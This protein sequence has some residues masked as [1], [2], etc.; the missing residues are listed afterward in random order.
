MKFGLDPEAASL[1][2]ATRIERS[3][4]DP[5]TP[6]VVVTPP[7]D[8]VKSASAADMLAFGVLL[9]RTVQPLVEFE[10]VTFW[11]AEA[12][13]E[14]TMSPLA[15]VGVCDVFVMLVPFTSVEVVLSSDED[16]STPEYSAMQ[17]PS[18]L[19][20]LPCTDTVHEPP[21]VFSR[22]QMPES[23]ALLEVEWLI[24]TDQLPAW[25]LSVTDTLPVFATWTVQTSSEPAVTL[26]E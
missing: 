17:M 15:P 19:A 7:D 22:Y 14:T 24:A 5:E 6:H 2:E 25:R 9:V 3:W 21:S 4:A 1:N 20:P 23:L 18:M 8:H 11:F 13:T 12:S 26:D 16:V 10:Y